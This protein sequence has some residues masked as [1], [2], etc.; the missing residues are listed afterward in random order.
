LSTGDV[1]AV[2]TSWKPSIARKNIPKQPSL[3]DLIQ[4][5][6][7][8]MFAFWNPMLRAE[9]ATQT[10]SSHSIPIEMR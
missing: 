8:G 7:V 10:A 5:T 2:A 4:K 3:H 6:A 1:H 9:A